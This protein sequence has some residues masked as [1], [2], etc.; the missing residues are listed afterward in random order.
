MMT[1][2]HLGSWLET[3]FLSNDSNEDTLMQWF[4]TLAVFKTLGEL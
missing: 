2:C 3:K 4:L 1:V